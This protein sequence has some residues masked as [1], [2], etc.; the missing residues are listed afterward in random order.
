MTGFDIIFTNKHNDFVYTTNRTCK[1]AFPLRA[2][3]SLSK[4]LCKSYKGGRFGLLK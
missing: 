3:L 1:K 4:K 2:D